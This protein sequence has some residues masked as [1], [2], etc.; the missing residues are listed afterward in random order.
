[1]RITA[2]PPR[3]YRGRSRAGPPP[4]RLTP[5][6]KLANTAGTGLVI[7]EVYGGGG[8]SGATLKNDFIEL[9]TRPPR[10]SAWPAGPSSGVAERHG[11]SHRGDAAHRLGPRRRAL[12]RAAGCRQRWHDQPAHPGRH[13]DHRDGWQQRHRDP[14]QFDHR[15]RPRRR[16]AGRPD[17]DRRPGRRRQQR[18]GGHQQGARDVQHGVVEASASGATPTTTSPTSRPARRPRSTPR[19]RAGS[20]GPVR[21]DHRTDPGHGCRGSVAGSTATTQGVMTAIYPRAPQRFRHPDRRHRRR[22]R[23]HPRR[24][25]RDLRLRRHVVRQRAGAR[26]RRLRAGH[27]RGH[28]VL[29]QHPDH[30]DAPQALSPSSRPRSRR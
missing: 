16:L 20:S 10:R 26:R 14:V 7:S 4:G 8:N 3:S 2:L 30:R 23:R 28:R 11:R 9:T 6:R 13:R 18:V 21:R 17:G 27:G 24:L 5:P 25:R 22:H 15:D 12:S 1:M 29:R 19:A